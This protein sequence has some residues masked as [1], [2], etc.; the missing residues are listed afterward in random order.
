MSLD[1]NC[2]TP[3]SGIR[4]H[5][6]WRARNTG[7]LIRSRWGSGPLPVL[8]WWVRV[9]IAQTGR[10]LAQSRTPDVPFDAFNA[11]HVTFWTRTVVTHSLVVVAEAMKHLV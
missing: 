9:T 7:E 1:G 5:Y 11:T 2:F 10:S 8:N 3:G 6:F 4:F